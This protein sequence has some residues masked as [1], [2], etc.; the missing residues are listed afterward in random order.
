M[1]G[2]VAHPR[3]DA[4]HQI[5]LLLNQD[6]DRENRHLAV[7]HKDA[8]FVEQRTVHVT[9]SGQRMMVS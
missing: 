4:V 7:K 5:R 1:L 3:T 9:Q 2:V 6:E 8:E